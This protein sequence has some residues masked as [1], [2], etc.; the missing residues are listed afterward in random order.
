[1]RDEGLL[2]FIGLGVREHEFHRTA[3]KTGVVDVILT[4]LDY[5]LLSQTSADS[6]LPFA[7]EHDIGV[8][9]GSPIAMGLLASAFRALCLLREGFEILLNAFSVLGRDAFCLARFEI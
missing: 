6:L 8:I 3:I 9:N 4:Y 7:A 2:R 1:M 5:T